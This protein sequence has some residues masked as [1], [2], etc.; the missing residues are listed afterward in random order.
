MTG[1]FKQALRRI[2]KLSIEQLR[3][4]LVAASSEISMLQ[5]VLDS[6]PSGILI[7]NEKHSLIMVNKSAYRLLSMSPGESGVLWEQITDN[8]ISAFFKHT[9]CSGETIMESEIEAEVFDKKSLLSVSIYP[10]VDKKHIT[11]SLIYIEDINEKRSREIK[12]RRAE[13]LAS[14]TTVAAG[15]AHEIKNPLGSISIHLQLIQKKLSG[16][17]DPSVKKYFNILN[18]EVERLNHIVV[19]FLF[20]VRPMTLNL[21]KRNINSLLSEIAGFINKE[22]DMSKI[23]L[24]MEL[25]EDI[26]PVLLDERYMKQAILNMIKNAKAAMPH[27]G[28]LTIATMGSENEIKI[29][30]CDTGTG[31]KPDNI[32]NI[33]EP[34][35]TTRNDGTGLGLTLVY[36]I[37]REHQGEITV[38]SRE[39]AGTNFEI[40]LPVFHTGM[41]LISFLGEKNEK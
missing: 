7:C 25:D 23:R 11:G 33:F 12:L 21:R 32:K 28:L 34:Y 9:L 8:S 4:L 16:L 1:F 40:I 6:L 39:G 13:S 37:I 20:A 2:N 29:S 14:L 22:L 3:E 5:I 41:P 36:K 26:L 17:K 15:I 30:I 10:L 24:L 38:E 18:E 31:I 35:F 27:G 19:D